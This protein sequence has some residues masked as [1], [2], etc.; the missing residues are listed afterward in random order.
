MKRQH[1]VSNYVE[2]ANIKTSKHNESEKKAELPKV[3]QKTIAWQSIFCQ[4][5]SQRERKFIV[6]IIEFSKGE[7]GERYLRFYEGTSVPQ[8]LCKVSTPYT[9]EHKIL[10]NRQYG[11]FIKQLESQGYTVKQGQWR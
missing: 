9:N 7:T 1:P 4:R 11:E 2:P 10:F 5:N 3:E 6:E 8:V